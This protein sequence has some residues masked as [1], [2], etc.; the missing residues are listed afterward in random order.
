MLTVCASQIAVV[1][2]FLQ[3][4]ASQRKVI[5]MRE[6]ALLKSTMRHVAGLLVKNAIVYHYCRGKLRKFQVT[7]LPRRGHGVPTGLLEE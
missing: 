4:T 5:E 1:M 6:I 3:F 2:D 7:A